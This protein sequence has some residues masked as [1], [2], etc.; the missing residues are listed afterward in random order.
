MFRNNQLLQRSKQIKD[1]GNTQDL[2]PVAILADP[3]EAE[4]GILVPV[5]KKFGF[6][7]FEARDGAVALDLA[8]K[9]NASLIIASADMPMISGAQLCQKVREDIGEIPFILISP[10]NEFPATSA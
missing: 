1:S 10:K 7:V 4:A 8:V 3:Y 9:N 2:R 5:L 6:S